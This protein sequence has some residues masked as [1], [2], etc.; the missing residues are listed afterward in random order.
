MNMGEITKGLLVKDG[1]G[2]GQLNS[3]RGIWSH[4]IVGKDN[5]VMVYLCVENKK[6]LVAE[7]SF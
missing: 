7:G 2:A 1:V 6:P 5:R 4:G 3:G